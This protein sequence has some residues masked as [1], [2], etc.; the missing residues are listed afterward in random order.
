LLRL[1]KITHLHVWSSSGRTLMTRPTKAG[2][3]AAVRLGAV[4]RVVA[5][6]AVLALLVG[7]IPVGLAVTVGNP[8][9]GWQDVYVGDV[10]DSAIIAV[11]A[12]LTWAAWA[13]FAGP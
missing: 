9:P 5:A 6:A 11:L 1:V 3:P 4:V 7:G 10:N 12:T 13:S 2:P 8:W